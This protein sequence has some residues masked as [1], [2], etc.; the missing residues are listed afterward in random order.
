MADIPNKLL[1]ILFRAWQHTPI[2]SSLQSQGEE[3][4]GVSKNTTT[5]PVLGALCLVKEK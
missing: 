4:Q 5:F 1:R 3:N 2:I